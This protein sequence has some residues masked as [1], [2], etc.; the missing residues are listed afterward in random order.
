MRGGEGWLLSFNFSLTFFAI[1]YKFSYL[2][3]PVLC[4][5]MPK[6]C[7]YCMDEFTVDACSFN[8]RCC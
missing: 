1:I 5:S 4:I 8:H 3:C 2:L 7:N 6:S